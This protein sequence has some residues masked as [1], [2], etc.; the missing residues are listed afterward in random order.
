MKSAGSFE[1]ALLLY[2]VQ[3]FL[4]AGSNGAVWRVGTGFITAIH[5]QQRAIL[6]DGSHYPAVIN[7]PAVAADKEFLFHISPPQ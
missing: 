1:P 2:I 7:A 3:F 6:R 5:F 4:N